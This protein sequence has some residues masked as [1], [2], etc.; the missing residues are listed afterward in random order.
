MIRTAIV[1]CGK[2]ADQHASQI[3]KIRNATLVAAC[4]S[5][6]LMAKQIAERF[7]ISAW[8]TDVDEM[9]AAARPD[10]VHVTTPPQSHLEIG[11]KCVEAGACAYIEKPFTLNTP[12]AMELINLA[13]RKGPKLTA[14]HNG[15]FTHAMNQMRGLVAHG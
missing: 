15:Q 6:P 3:R 1:G 11:K 10:V 4:D 5:D 13:N 14:G 7:E 2:M 12:D 9:L 8:F